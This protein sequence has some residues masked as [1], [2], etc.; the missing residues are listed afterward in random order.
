MQLNRFV[1]FADFIVYPFVIAILFVA[2]L[3][4][5]W[6]PSWIELASGCAC[7]VTIWSLLEYLI[8]RFALHGIA[9]FAAMHKMHHSDP[10][11]LLG[12]PVWLS[13]GA[14]CC[15]ALV[16]L[17]VSIGVKDACSVTA[18]LVLG[19]LWFGLVH[20]RIHHSHPRRGTHFSSLKRQHVLHHYG[21][22]QCNFGVITSLWDRIFGTFR[23]E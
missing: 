13:L 19:Y 12:T 20:H 4:Q 3:R 21:K 9:Y 14:I 8:H 1:Y 15:G 17:W 6:P 2:A 22:A 5:Q 7:G 23:S 18:G 11:A 16:P 10:K